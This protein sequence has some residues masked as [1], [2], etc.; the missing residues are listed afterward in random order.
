MVKPNMKAKKKAGAEASRNISRI[1]GVVE[2]AANKNTFTSPNLFVT[3]AV[4]IV[5]L[6]LVAAQLLAGA[7]P[8]QE[9]ALSMLNQRAEALQKTADPIQRDSY[10]IP[11]SAYGRSLDRALDKNARVFFAGLIGKTNA[12][13]VGYYYFLQNYLFPRDLEISLDGHAVQTEDYFDGV[14]CDSPAV[15]QTNGFDLMIRCGANGLQLIP[16]TT[17]GTPHE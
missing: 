14:P 15:L 8:D 13:G 5:A 10:C 12:G 1:V 11:L 3:L 2:T 9:I 7:R 16:L 6:G 17:R 4:G